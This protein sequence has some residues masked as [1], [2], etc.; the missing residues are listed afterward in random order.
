MCRLPNPPREIRDGSWLFPAAE[1]FEASFYL[2]SRGRDWSPFS[3]HPMPLKYRDV[4]DEAER[5]VCPL[6]A[7][8]IERLLIHWD[9]A[10]LAWHAAR[11]KSDNTSRRN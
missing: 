2:L 3:G 5:C 8:R 7:A 9:D 4:R 11:A 10:F 1:P 6:P